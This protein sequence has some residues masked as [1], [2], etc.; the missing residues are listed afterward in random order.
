MLINII[1]KQQ[2][3]Q[4][5]SIKMR[6]LTENIQQKVNSLYKDNNDCSNF[7]NIIPQKYSSQKDWPIYLDNLF[8]ELVEKGHTPID[9]CLKCE[10]NIKYIDLQY[11]EY[12]DF[13]HQYSK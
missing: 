9:T 8:E 6:V 3:M 7:R 12:Y 13:T 2:I 4:T 1:K 5:T 11:K 10:E